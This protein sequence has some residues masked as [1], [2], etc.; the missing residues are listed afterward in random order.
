MTDPRE[1]L[2]RPAPGPQ[3]THPYGPGRDE[4]W[5]SY[6]A[7]RT[8]GG[9]HGPGRRAGAPRP[10]VALVHGG[11]WWPDYDRTHLRPLAAALA[12]RGFPV[13]SLEYP[14]PGM[15]RGGWPQT[16]DAVRAGLR[17]VVQA[18]TGA[19]TGPVVA[20]GHSAGGH[21]AVLAVSGD[22]P[23]PLAGVVSLAGVLDLALAEAMNLDDG[24]ARALLGTAPDADQARWRSAD[25]TRQRHH[26]PVVALHGESDVTVPPALSRSWSRSRTPADAAHTLTLLPDVEHYGLIDPTS[27]QFAVLTAAIEELA[28][29]GIRCPA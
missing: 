21:L 15:P 17:A 1:V 5:E 3:A 12:A 9:A 14:R 6:A 27:P 22:D 2:T 4:V 18:A 10:T 23:V 28:G 25:P 11:F 13:A 20:V 8:D 16:G 29:P 26:V 19:N 24:A 7:A